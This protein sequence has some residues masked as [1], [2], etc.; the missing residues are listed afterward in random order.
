MF[1]RDGVIVRIKLKYAGRYANSYRVTRPDGA[2]G[3][4]MQR[5]QGFVDV[6]YVGAVDPFDRGQAKQPIYWP[7]DEKELESKTL[8]V[9]QLDKVTRKLGWR[10]PGR[11]ILPLKAV[12]D[13]IEVAEVPRS[14]GFSGLARRNGEE[15][16]EGEARPVTPIYRATPE[17]EQQLKEI[18]KGKGK[19]ASERQRERKNP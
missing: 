17:A 3:W 16:E 1:R 2:V 5:P 6:P 7:E 4:Q 19:A 12:A 18:E 8:E 9:A 11:Y 13:V 14:P 10:G 15:D